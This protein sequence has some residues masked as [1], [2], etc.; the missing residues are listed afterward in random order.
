MRLPLVPFGSRQ[1]KK[2]KLL[3]KGTD[4]RHLQQALKQLGFFSARVDGVFGYKTFGAVREFQRFFNLRQSGTVANDDFNILKELMQAGINKWYTPLRDFAYSGYLPFSISKELRHGRTWSISNIIALNSISDRLIV[5][6]P[7]QILAIG[8]ISGDVLWKNTRVF[9]E[10]PPV[11]SEGQLLI[12]AQNLEIIDL[13]SGK[14]LYSLNQNIFTTSVAAKGSKIYAPTGGTI[15]AFDRKGNTLWKYRTSGAFCT[16]P[17]LGYDLIY[18]ASY[19]RN[20]YCLDDKGVLYWKTKISD[21]VKLPLAL[22]DGKI[23]AVSQDSWI[24][25]IN[26]LVGKIIWQKKL[27]DEE[28]LRPAFHPDFMLL[29]NYKGQVTALSFQS[30]KIKWATDLPAAPT[31]SP[32]ALK[33]TFFIGTEDGLMAYNAE[34]LEYNRYLEGEK[35]TAIMPA[36]LSLFVSTDKKIVRLLPK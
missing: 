20:I 10:A 18:F 13:Y 30:A 8:L 27:S 21:I 9:P 22:W 31:T 5:T 34:T 4:V 2:Q 16:S 19:D 15:Y 6:T 32:I 14:G 1:L 24:C 23:F 26:P 3:I 7:N 17:A 28:F 12:P 25:A 35:I 29:V 11:I 33:E 36:A